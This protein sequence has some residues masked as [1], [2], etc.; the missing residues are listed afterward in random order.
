MKIL[1][2]VAE[3]FYAERRMDRRTGGPDEANRHFCNLENA[4]KYKKDIICYSISTN[5][6]YITYTLYFFHVIFYYMFRFSLSHLQGEFRH[7]GNYV[8]VH[9][10][11]Y[12]NYRLTKTSLWT[13]LLYCNH[14]VHRDILNTLYI[15]M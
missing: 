2:V 14:Q 7:K 15:R 4:P 13:W 12:L 10:N 11:V 6:S 9:F 3:F 1:P 8:V 5:C